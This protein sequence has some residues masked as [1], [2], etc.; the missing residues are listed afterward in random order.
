MNI[1]T[2]PCLTWNWM[3]INQDKVELSVPFT[4]T[5]L[6]LKNTSENLSISEKAFDV[7]GFDQIG[8]GCANFANPKLNAEDHAPNPVNIKDVEPVVIHKL[9]EHPLNQIIDS[10][11]TKPQNLTIR[12]KNSEPFV[13][14][15]ENCGKENQVAAQNII[16]EKDSEATLILLYKNQEE[17]ASEI[18]QIIRTRIYV[19][20]NASLHIVKVQLLNKNVNQIDDTAF[21][22]KDNS[23]LD[24]TQ[25]ELGANHISSG[26]HT[27]LSGYQSKFT[28]N[29]AYMC[30]DNQYLDM[31][32][33]V[34]HFGQKSECNMKV[35][36]SLKDNSTKVYRGI[37]DLK[38]GCCGS[39]GHEMEETLLL[40]PKVINKSLPVILCDEEDVE[41]VH[42]STI[43]RLSGDILF[44]MQ[45]R[46]ISQKEAEKIMSVAKI[47]AVAEL[48]TDETITDEIDAYLEKNFLQD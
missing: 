27:T 4:E 36:G 39:K 26:L 7:S 1:N 20:E 8:S 10:A 6:V 24:F 38:K 32:H 48:I 28:S 22:G 17:A 9:E 2:I 35:N 33:V 25:I 15:V 45:T 44:Y 12:G 31:N 23:K 5:K 37:I 3:K 29:V 19:E 47:Q 30:Q 21:V 42:G 43:G 18:T 13:F 40:N 11:V 34:Y 41:G 14:T 16:A 46:G